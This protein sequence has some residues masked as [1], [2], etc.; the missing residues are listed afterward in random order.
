MYRSNK[1]VSLKVVLGRVAPV[2]YCQP[3]ET[4]QVTT[5]SSVNH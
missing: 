4:S 1:I 5:E 2:F 3:A